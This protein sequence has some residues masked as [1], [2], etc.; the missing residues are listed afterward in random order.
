MALLTLAVNIYLFIYLLQ[1]ENL[2]VCNKIMQ[3]NDF[4]Y[5]MIINIYSSIKKLYTAY[6]T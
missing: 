5:L 2:F 3:I 1:Q 4:I 6:G